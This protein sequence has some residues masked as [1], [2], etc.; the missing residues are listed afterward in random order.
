MVHFVSNLH[1]FVMDRNLFASWAELETE[2]ER[3]CSLD[4]AIAAHRAFLVKVQRQCLLLPDKTWRLL[5][6][7]ILNILT[8]I[9]QWCHILQEKVH[10]HPS[11]ANPTN[12][13]I[14]TFMMI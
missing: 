2:M 9:L 7:A 6:T 10:P 13:P 14:L 8:Q 1:Q 3:A 11:L 4:D 5:E 12:N